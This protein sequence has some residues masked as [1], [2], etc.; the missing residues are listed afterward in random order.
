M[1]SKYNVTC[2]I[3]AVHV[4]NYH[5][6]YLLIAHIILKQEG[7][8]IPILRLMHWVV[9]Y[10]ATFGWGSKP[11]FQGREQRGRDCTVGKG[12]STVYEVLE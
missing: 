10:N 7:M 9:I 11:P 6:T 1:H 4:N 12:T 5:N 3:R 2:S 8:A